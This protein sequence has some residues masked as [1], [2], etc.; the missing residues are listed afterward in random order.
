MAEPRGSSTN[1]ATAE[2]APEATEL[3]SREDPGSAT[4][5]KDA[6][7][8]NATNTSTDSDSL[9]SCSSSAVT[10]NGISDSERISA[11][12]ALPINNGDAPILEVEAHSQK[13]ESLRPLVDRR[14][15]ELECIVKDIEQSHAFVGAVEVLWYGVSSFFNIINGFHSLFKK[16]PAGG[17]CTRSAASKGTENPSSNGRA[18][19]KSAVDSKINPKP[20]GYEELSDRTVEGCFLTLEKA[21]SGLVNTLAKTKTVES[22]PEK[23]LRRSSLTMRFPD[24]EGPWLSKNKLPWLRGLIADTIHGELFRSPTSDSRD[25]QVEHELEGFERMLMDLHANE[26]ETK[27]SPWYMKATEVIEELHCRQTEYRDPEVAVR[28]SEKIRSSLEPAFQ[29]NVEANEVLRTVSLMAVCC[30]LLLHKRPATYSWD[31]NANLPSVN[32]DR[33]T[34]VGGGRRNR[35]LNNSVEFEVAFTVF[36]AVVKR[37]SVI[38]DAEN[39]NRGCSILKPVVVVN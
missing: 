30:A 27:D 37:S 38:G 32:K 5:A 34:I 9:S 18:T 1:N 24:K 39:S 36:G 2:C 20:D 29:D 23:S 11:S 28:L 12:E 33:A 22:I 35:G 31:Q 3:L 16:G 13:L 7:A 10:L 25:D 14:L 4:V 19:E 17:G 6:S 26:R 8:P 15:R 21:V